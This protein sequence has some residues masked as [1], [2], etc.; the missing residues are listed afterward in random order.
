M[1]SMTQDPRDGKGEDNKPLVI[2]HQ[3]VAWISEKT[4][5]QAEKAVRE[6]AADEWGPL[7]RENQG[8]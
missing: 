3:P 8:R 5:R 7:I 1:S 4:L 6:Q 2:C